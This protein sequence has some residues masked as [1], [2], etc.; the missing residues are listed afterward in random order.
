MWVWILIGILWALNIGL[1]RWLGGV[2]AAGEAIESWGLLA[3]RKAAAQAPGT[4]RS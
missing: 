2:A 3:S 1:L 4:R